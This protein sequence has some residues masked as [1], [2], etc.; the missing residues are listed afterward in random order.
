MIQLMNYPLLILINIGQEKLK[1]MV[2]QMFK[3][4]YLVINQILKMTNK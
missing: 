4:Y 2:N 1:I 3:F